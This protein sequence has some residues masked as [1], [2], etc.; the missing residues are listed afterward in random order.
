[1]S[2]LKYRKPAAHW[3]EALP[4][5]NGH[6]GAM[7][8][9]DPFEELISLN[10]ETL[11]YRGYTDRNNPDSLKYL[12]EIRQLLLEEKIEEA[13][14]LTSLAMFATP[15]DQSHYA[16]L[17]DISITQDL[18]D[19]DIS[20]YRRELD[21][22]KSVST[23]NF[24][25]GDNHYKRE[26]FVDLNK[27][28]LLIKYSS[29][30]DEKVNLEI[31]LGRHKRFNDS[32]RKF[33]NNGLV[34]KASA[35][36][37]NGTHFEL[38]TKVFSSDGD[39]KVI[40][41][42]IVVENASEVIIG[43]TSA[44]DYYSNG[45]PLECEQK[46]ID[47]NLENYS[48][49]KKDH[50]KEYGKYFNR[51]E[52][53]LGDNE[54]NKKLTALPTD[55]RLALVKKGGVDTGLLQLY[56]DYGRYLL[57]SSSQPGGLA[58]NLQGIWSDSIDPIWGSKYTININIQMNYWLTGPCDLPELEYPL[59]EMLKNMRENG[60]ITA[61]K[62]YGARGFTAHHNTDGFFDTAPQS[63]AIGAA[64]WPMTVAWLSTHIWEHYQF[65]Q[66]KDILEKYF[67]VMKEAVLFYTDYLFLHEGR[68]YTG[69]SVSPENKYKT[70]NN[71]IGNLTV[72][73]TV[74]NQILRFFF[75][76]Y[77]KAG[78]IIGE[79]L[80]NIAHVKE[81]KSKLPKTKI[82]SHGQIQEWIKDYEEV[83]PGHRHISQL[84]GLHP[85]QEISVER[86]PE[87]AKAAEKTIA[88]RLEYSSFLDPEDREGAIDSWVDIGTSE[89]KR[90]GW[91][92]AWMVNFYARLKKS[93]ASL[94]ELYNLLKN[95]SLD[96][97][98]CDHPPFQIDGNFG[99]VNGICEMLV[100]SHEEYIEFLPALPKEFSKGK[101]KGAKVRGGQKIDF[102]WNDGKIENI[103]IHG[104]PLD[105]V[106][107]KVD[108]S[109]TGNNKE[110][111]QEVKLSD[112][113]E[114]ELNF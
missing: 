75:D 74:D 18:D 107:V 87:L 92:S 62:M 35:G 49:I 10:D 5:G 114:I 36:G 59:L 16:I 66:N 113:G 108:A 91:S 90:T 1:M 15:R 27:T 31:K 68:L 97:L 30:R 52:L 48:Q 100:Q 37:I 69:P 67:P 3:N 54:S 112:T 86:T 64:I 13:E 19:N 61:K 85:G 39:I 101:F 93:E 78:K 58:A 70:K 88:R 26:Y 23:I 9:G 105:K 98:L 110:Y 44:S 21:I 50:I 46:L 94:E 76:S 55:Q 28:G 43:V 60:K 29:S 63:R 73:P 2:V 6:M 71:V 89:A 24:D 33:N 65:T 103:K 42:T 80:E 51:V 14:K 53:S 7:I 57:I 38:G 20:N 109:K 12:D 47:M 104:E 34:M 95:S 17:G 4:M 72:S 25:S 11:W 79:D 96:N 84:F 77:I 111:R 22:K 106:K 45:M 99:A 102:S 32:I 8:H 81:M 83:E 56:F 40:G 41:E 82:G